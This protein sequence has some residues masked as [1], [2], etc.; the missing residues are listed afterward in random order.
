M[1]NAEP[2]LAAIAS[3]VA[4]P[5]R[6]AIVSELFDGRALP[7]GELERVAGVSPATASAHLAKMVD[8][9]LLDVLPQGRHRYYRIASADVAHALETLGALA[10]RRAVKSLR[11]A[12]RAERLRDARSCYDH[13]A[14]RIAIALASA[15]VERG[16]LERDGDGFRI[17][18]N[19]RKTLRDLGVDID[20][21]LKRE[22]EHVRGCMDWTERR[23]HVGGALGRA[24]LEAFLAQGY[25]ERVAE[26]RVLR[27][28]PQG[29]A[30]LKSFG[31]VSAGSET[32]AG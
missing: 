32:K 12:I 8:G 20:A 17:G 10:P 19:G 31:V 3:L 27:I 1:W 25:F 23:P 6:A 9:G 4:E 18:G 2:D 7:A 14:G 30:M 5:A 28:T 16:V 15:F 29:E 22:N 11:G 24:L 13:L 26:P 21:I